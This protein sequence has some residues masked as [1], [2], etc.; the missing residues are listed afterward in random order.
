MYSL[1]HA[2]Q[3]VR[4]DYRKFETD[5]AVQLRYHRRMV[6]FWIA[7][8]IPMN[9]IVTLDILATLGHFPARIALLLTAV[10]LAINTNYSLYAN[11]DTEMGDAH[12]A[13]AGVKADE[14]QH[15][16]AQ[17]PQVIEANF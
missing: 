16:Q 1:R 3:V 4:K 11:L 12:A 8:F 9:V 13:Y 6:L 15:G 10:L 2:V 7:N 14:I 5:P 17:P